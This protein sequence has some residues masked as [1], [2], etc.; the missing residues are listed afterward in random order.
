MDEPRERHWMAGKH[1]LRYLRGT[2]A[3]GL[4]YT[5]SSSVMLH[6]YA[7]SSWAGSPKEYLRLLLQFRISDDLLVRPEAGIY[8]S[9]H[10]WGWIYCCWQCQQRA[11]FHDRSK[12]IDL[13]YHYIRDMVQWN[14]IKLKYIVTDEQVADILTKPLPLTKFA[15]FRG[16]LGVAERASLSKREYWNQHQKAF[17]KSEVKSDHPEAS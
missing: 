6:G 7:D 4:K 8:C 17:S 16:K 14:V 15:H 11:V 10:S 13:K 2:I 12:H 3:Y 1:V 5:S 9:E